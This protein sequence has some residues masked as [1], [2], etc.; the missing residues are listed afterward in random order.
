MKILLTAITVILFASN[1]FAFAEFGAIAH[2]KIATSVYGYAYDAKDKRSAQI[3]ALNYCGKHCEILTVFKNGCIAYATD[4]SLNSFV[5]G[6][7]RSAS[8]QYAAKL[9]VKDCKAKSKQKKGA[10]CKLQV[11]FCNKK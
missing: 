10:G 7:G 3:S 9:A 5:V 8:K 1:Q 2:H 6:L 11:S 4:E